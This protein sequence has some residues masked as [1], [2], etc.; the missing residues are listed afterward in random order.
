MPLRWDI[1]QARG[2]PLGGSSQNFREIPFDGP[3]GGPPSPASI[4]R[5]ALGVGDPPLAVWK[6]LCVFAIAKTLQLQN[7]PKK[8]S[9][10]MVLRPARARLWLVAS[11][12][13]HKG[14]VFLFNASLAPPVEAAMGASCNPAAPLLGLWPGLTK[15][16]RSRPF[17]PQHPASHPAASHPRTSSQQLHPPQPWVPSPSPR[18]HAAVY[19][20]TNRVGGWQVVARDFC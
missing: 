8:K 9:Q 2:Y 4:P 5:R 10:K 18:N 1:A 12:A 14:R 6:K 17:A 16:D 11:H 7:L 13:V 19:P 3:F 20:L 15:G